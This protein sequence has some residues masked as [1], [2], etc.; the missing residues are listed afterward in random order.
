M[1]RQELRTTVMNSS[2]LQKFTALKMSAPR[3][4]PHVKMNRFIAEAKRVHESTCVHN[5]RYTL[6]SAT[7]MIEPQNTND[8]APFFARLCVQRKAT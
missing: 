6:F 5:T 4:R 8:N 1:L 3:T 7:C 2:N